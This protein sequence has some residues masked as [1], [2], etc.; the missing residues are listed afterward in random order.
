MCVVSGE[1]FYKRNEKSYNFGS[2]L[3]VKFEIKSVFVYFQYNP[4]AAPQYPCFCTKIYT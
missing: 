1:Q 3:K 2:H 4:T